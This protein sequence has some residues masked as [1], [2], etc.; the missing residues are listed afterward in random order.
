MEQ[1]RIPIGK[2]IKCSPVTNCISPT[3]PQKS[4]ICTEDDHAHIPRPQATTPEGYAKHL[5]NMP[6][7]T[8]HGNQIWKSGHRGCPLHPRL[9]PLDLMSQDHTILDGLNDSSDKYCEETDTCQPLANS[10]KTNLKNLKSNTPQSTPTEELSLL[11]DKLQH[12]AMVL[13][14]APPVK[15]E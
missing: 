10:L 4:L 5:W 6:K 12:L 11:T 8:W 14:P 1:S 9:N 7:D 2:Q 15:W 3:P 13:Q